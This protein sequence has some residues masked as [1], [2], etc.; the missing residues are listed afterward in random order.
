MSRAGR[1]R[2]ALAARE[3]K[4]RPQRMPVPE[5][6]ADVMAVARDAPHRQGIVDRTGPQPRPPDPRDP[7]L[8]T[9][10]GRLRLEA[11]ITAEQY[12]AGLRWGRIVI[13]MCRAIAAPPGSPTGVLA[14]LDGIGGHAREMSAEEVAEARQ[15]YDDAHCALTRDL[16]LGHRRILPN[17]LRQIIVEDRPCQDLTR[18]RGALDILAR[19]FEAEGMRSRLM[20]LTQITEVY[21][22]GHMG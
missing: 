3:R 2:K 11:R 13:R 15:A 14:A 17:L 6:A 16:G 4:G 21:D 19:Y 9:E 20:P 22:D 8:G 12:A 5:R 10:F 18:L 7:R 1:K